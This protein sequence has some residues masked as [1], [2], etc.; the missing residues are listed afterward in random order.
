MPRLALQVTHAVHVRGEVGPGFHTEHPTAEQR[1]EYEEEHPAIFEHQ[2]LYKVGDNAGYRRR[3]EASS[4]RR[5][6]T[7]SQLN[8]GQCNLKG[9]RCPVVFNGP[10]IDPR[11]PRMFILV[12]W[13]PVLGRF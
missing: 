1:V 7:T 9:T 11:P 4:R 12:R 10:P 6:C 5:L 8:A 3:L 2:H 13:I